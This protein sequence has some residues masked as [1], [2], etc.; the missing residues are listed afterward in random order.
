MQDCSNSS[1]LAMELLQSCAKPSKWWMTSP[2]YLWYDNNDI[3]L[4]H[5]SIGDWKDIS[6]AH[7]II[8][9]KSE[10][11]TFPIVI[12]FFRGCV[13]EMFVTSYPVIYCI[14]VPGNREFVFIIIVQFIMSEN[15]RIR[16]ALQIVLVCLYSTPSH[17]HHCA[18]PSEDIELIKCLSDIFCRVR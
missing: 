15:S 14:Y 13:P 6:I 10:V 7:V 8:I 5:F 12:I 2:T 17:Y 16:F 9:I 1:A 3:Q 11:S 4:A 18:K